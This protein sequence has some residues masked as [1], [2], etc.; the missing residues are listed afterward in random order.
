MKWKKAEHE[1]STLHDADENSLYSKRAFI[2]IL[3]IVHN[4]RLAKELRIAQ[5][6]FRFLA[7]VKNGSSNN[8]LLCE[9]RGSTTSEPFQMTRSPTGLHRS[10][11][12]FVNRASCR[13]S[14]IAL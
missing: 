3:M 4:L 2:H 13:A 6:S 9:D 10:T 5:D 8:C 14:T 12:N 11:N 7:E 1:D